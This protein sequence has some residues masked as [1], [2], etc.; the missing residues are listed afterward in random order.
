MNRV[1]A[2]R[3]VTVTAMGTAF[4]KLP[5]LGE[6]VEG[7]ADSQLREAMPSLPPGRQAV[8]HLPDRGAGSG[9]RA[10]Q[11]CRYRLRFGGCRLPHGHTGSWHCNRIPRFQAGRA[12]SSYHAANLEERLAGRHGDP[13]PLPGEHTLSIDCAR[14]CAMSWG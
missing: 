13:A 10:T 11:G 8:G 12:Q 14:L 9:P 2:L 7:R 4:T 1:T 5:L 3:V 6:G